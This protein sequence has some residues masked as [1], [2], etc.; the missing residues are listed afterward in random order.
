MLLFM[1]AVQSIRNTPA[2]NRFNRTKAM[3]LLTQ[4]IPPIASKLNLGVEEAT[5]MKVEDIQ[6]DMESPMELVQLREL[7]AELDALACSEDF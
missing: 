1:K 2:S 5:R 6:L 7:L 4:R 3:A